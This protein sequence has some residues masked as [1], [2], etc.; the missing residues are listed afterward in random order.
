MIAIADQE[1]SWCA[2]PGRI[3]IET[4]GVGYEVLI[5]LSTYY[6]L[7]ELG[8]RVGCRSARSFAKTR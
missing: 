8:E 2:T 3:V 4:G 6:R 5:P 1:R 7:P